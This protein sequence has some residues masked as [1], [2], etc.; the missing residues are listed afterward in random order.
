MARLA[1]GRWSAS[2]N[3]SAG[4]WTSERSFSRLTAA[5]VRGL[6]RA[7][8]G[9]HRARRSLSAVRH[10]LRVRTLFDDLWRNTDDRDVAVRAQGDRR[11]LCV[12]GRR[13]RATADRRRVG[14]RRGSPG[15]RPPRTSGRR[16]PGSL[17][18]RRLA[19]GGRVIPAARPC[20]M[21]AQ[22]PAGDE[23][24][25]HRHRRTP[26]V[27][28]TVVRSG[29]RFRPWPGTTRL[30]SPPTKLP[31]PAWKRTAGAQARRERS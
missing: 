30:P 14:S 25:R 1:A 26:F 21:I 6:G 16:I 2:R 29:V 12:R 17:I 18:E 10:G 23:A 24:D 7:P 22:P 5:C 9:G 20:I 27:Q 8:A 11:A 15:S 19:G 31:V 28:Q 4:S 13:R 3:S